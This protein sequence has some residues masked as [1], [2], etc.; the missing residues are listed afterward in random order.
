MKS[1]NRSP[2]FG[3]ALALFFALQVPTSARAEPQNREPQVWKRIEAIKDEE[4]F[5][6]A[7]PVPFF[8]IEQQRP[9]PFRVVLE[10]EYDKEGSNRM[11]TQEEWA[12]IHSYEAAIAKDLQRDSLGVLALTL[13]SDGLCQIVSYVREA[14]VGQ[15]RVLAALPSEGPRSQGDPLIVIGY[16]AAS[17]KSWSYVTVLV[18]AHPIP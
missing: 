9:F 13:A 12:R 11:P 16:S 8:T 18:R 5:S 3:F 10:Y 6:L 14:G 17:D 2:L 7:Y 4:R 15:A 1:V